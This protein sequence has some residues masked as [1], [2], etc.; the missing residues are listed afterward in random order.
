MANLVLAEV[1]LKEGDFDA[2]EVELQAIEET[3]PK[4]DFFVLGNIQRIRGLLA[5]E[6][7][8]EELAVHHFSHG[9]TIFEA[10]E[11]LYHK[12]LTHYLIGKT[13]SENQPKKAFKHLISAGEIFRK[14]DI[15][16][17]C[18]EIEERIKKLK[19]NGGK[20]KS[21]D[22]AEKSEHSVSSQLLMLRLAEATAS[23]ELIFRELV[24]ILQ[25]ESKAQK[26]IIIEID[27]E[28][29]FYPFITHG[30]APNESVQMVAKLQEA[31]FKNELDKFGKAK[32]VQVFQLRAPSSTP[33]FLM[34]S[35]R[36]S[37]VLENGGSI[38]PLLRVVEL[39]MDVCA[40]RDRDKYQTD[41]QEI[42]PYTSNSLM[43]GFISFF[44]GD[45]FPCRRSL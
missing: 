35:P 29:K 24:A 19:K 1:H 16:P 32:N 17:I 39:G 33:A 22:F 30:Y 10:A 40:L 4:S 45:D 20:T 8:D 21:A 18:A 13:I 43:P 2:C 14:L 3:D 42:S 44:A 12:A 28:K 34:I 25:Q 6:Y 27:D 31:H 26:I 15:E 5:L 23:R 9:L 38:Q 11:D 41:E 7:G 37:A 36:S